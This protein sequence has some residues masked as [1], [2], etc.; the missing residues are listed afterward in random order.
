MYIFQS[1]TWTAYD[2]VKTSKSWTRQYE[3]SVKT[4]R[5]SPLIQQSKRL[6][7]D[8]GVQLFIN[9]VVSTNS[10]QAAASGVVRDMDDNWILGF[11]HI[12][13]NCGPLEAELRG[14]MD[15]ILILIEN[16]FLKANIWTDNLEV[17]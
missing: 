4:T 3:A 15:E 9:G 6:Y 14:I 1:I 5:P 12:L 2:I 16:G 10:R 7:K 8:L 13:G 17:V 11:N